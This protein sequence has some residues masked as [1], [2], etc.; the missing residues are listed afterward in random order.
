M[1]IK[2]EDQTI[3]SIKYVGNVPHLIFVT[4]DMGP[5]DTG[6]WVK[7]TPGE[8]YIKARESAEYYFDV[9]PNVKGQANAPTT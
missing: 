4:V 8:I 6:K 9:L 7:I 2:P 5:I 3:L 1:I